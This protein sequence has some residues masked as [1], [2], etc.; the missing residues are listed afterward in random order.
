ME[1]M[2]VK[3]RDAEAKD[4]EA[5]RGLVDYLM[6][7]EEAKDIRGNAEKIMRDRILPS[8]KSDISKTFVAEI[9]GRVVGFLLVEA[10]RNLVLSLAYIA[11]YPEN[12]NQGIGGKLLEKTEEYA[13]DKDIHILDVL[14]HKDNKKS[15]K[16]HESKGFKL[17]GYNLRK[18]SNPHEIAEA[19]DYQTDYRGL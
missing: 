19:D 6:K 1:T 18:E 4:I 5:I 13:K 3:I 14:V 12:H 10:K 8:L 7:V 9:D 2:Q 16:F 11:I 17:F 15:R